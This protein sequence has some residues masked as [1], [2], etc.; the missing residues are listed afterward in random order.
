MATSKTNLSKE[1]NKTI[2]QERNR[3]LEAER[4]TDEAFDNETEKLNLDDAP[5]LT[6][7]GVPDMRFIENRKSF[8]HDRKKTMKG[9]PDGRLK[10]NRPDIQRVHA[11]R[12]ENYPNVTFSGPG[13][14]KGEEQDEE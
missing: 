3:L 14:L 1:S 8:L 2:A 7:A 12:G 10:I 9:K 11:Q 13:K 6:A 5:V 4:Q